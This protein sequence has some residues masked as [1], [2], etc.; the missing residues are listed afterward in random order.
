VFKKLKEKVSQIQ[1]RG[2]ILIFVALAALIILSLIFEYYQRNKEFIKIMRTQTH[3]LLETTDLALKNALLTGRE[4]EKQLSSRLLNNAVLIKLLLE[5]G[6][7]NNKLL[8]KIAA[9]NDILRIN[10]FNNKGI[11]EFSSHPSPTEVNNS[12][13]FIYERLYPIFEDLTDTLIVGL[14]EARIGNQFRYIAALATED[15]GAIVLVLD[16]DKILN[17][18]RKI[19]FGALLK[20]L[21][22]DSKLVYAVLQDSSGFIAASGNFKN[23]EDIEDSPF[24]VS[25]LHSKNI[26]WRIFESDS[27]RVFEAVQVF[28]PGN[29]KIGLLRIGVSTDDFSSLNKRFITRLII[30]GAILILLGFIIMSFIFTSQSNLLLKKQYR[31][32]ET[33]SKK[34]L[35]NINDGI[36]VCDSNFNIVS[37]NKKGELIFNDPEALNKN[38]FDLIDDVKFKDILNI[39]DNN[40]Q[41]TLITNSDKRIY[42]VSFS[43]FLDENNSTNYIFVFT[44]LTKQKQLEEKINRQDRLSAMGELAGGVAHEIRNP[45]NTIGT[46]AQQL[47]KDFTPTEHNEEYF[48]LTKLIVKEVKRINQTI[49]DFLKFARPE[50]IVKSNFEINEIYTQL[51][52]QYKAYF[53]QKNIAFNHLLTGNCTVYWDKSKILQA[54][55]NILQNAYDAIKETGEISF[56]IKCAEKDVHITISDTG[57]GI[58]ADKLNKIFNLYY[59]TKAKGTGIGLSITQRIIFEHDGTINI[60]SEQNKGTTVEIIIP[61]G[62]NK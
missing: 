23:L 41:I 6:K 21:T 28:N 30:S 61:K 5:E 33:Y 17:F 60:N 22:D 51:T 8:N 25:S 18:R 38:I 44:D 14:R 19:G 1:P 20:S 43:T 59:T 26:N 55:M 10:I 15:N 36:I 34:V 52:E 50:P 13:N 39:K 11:K 32:I 42:D 62:I 7:V 4:V 40:L 3:A 16:G 56:Q 9:E 54:L 57:E 58:Q 24:L 49:T 29:N 27:I 12:T 2:L 53:N 47:N 37:I 46:I 48:N 31:S 35:L 45:L